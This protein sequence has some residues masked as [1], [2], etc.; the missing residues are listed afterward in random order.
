[1]KRSYWACLRVSKQILDFAEVF[2]KTYG[3][4]TMVQLEHENFVPLTFD[5]DGMLISLFD[6]YTALFNNVP[7]EVILKWYDN[8]NDFNLWTFYHFYLE[9]KD[10]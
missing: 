10:A 3:F 2:R 6:M 9:W 4:E 5:F 7:K 1:M 8:P